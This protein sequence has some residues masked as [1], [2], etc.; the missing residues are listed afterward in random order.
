MAEPY[1]NLSDTG[2]ALEAL[3]GVF[4]GLLKRRALNEYEKTQKAAS[5]YNVW[6]AGQQGDAILRAG[7]HDFNTL[8]VK[9]KLDLAAVRADAAA[10]GV[11]VTSGSTVDVAHGVDLAGA[12]SEN[13]T[14]ANAYSSARQQYD[15]AQALKIQMELDKQ[16]AQA[17]QQE[18]LTSMGTSFLSGIGSYGGALS[19]FA[20]LFGRT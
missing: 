13:R 6:A 17:A 20:G 11:S 3:G 1:K 9:N 8:H 7:V 5:R 10:R 4:G 18:N 12:A 15:E 2:T 14:I 19:S 16:R